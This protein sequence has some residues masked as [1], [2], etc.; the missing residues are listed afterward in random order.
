M[1]DDELGRQLPR[2]I[3]PPAHVRDATLRAVA[4][5]RAVRRW[6]RAG[7]S[8]VG[9]AAVALLAVMARARQKSA[10]DFPGAAR[11]LLANAHARPAFAELD[12]AEQ[13][14]EAALKAHPNDSELTDALMRIHRQRDA[15]QHLI[16]TANQ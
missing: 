8:A 10:S 6:Q 13:D 14:L 12:R 9:I 5:R 2:E 3:T 1:N 4:R 15:L 16:A 11:V 7:L